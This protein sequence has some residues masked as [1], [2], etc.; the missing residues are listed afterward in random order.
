MNDLIRFT[1]RLEKIVTLWSKCVK[2]FLLLF[3]D[4]HDILD[5]MINH[6]II[7][8]DDLRAEN[9]HRILRNLRRDGPHTRSNLGRQTGLSAASVST[10]ISALT[11][12]GI[13]HSVTDTL[14][15]SA[16]RG[17]PQSSITLSGAAAMVATV[18]LTIDRLYIGLVDY[19]GDALEHSSL[20]IDTRSLTTTELVNLVKR[21]LKNAV[22]LHPNT[23]LRHIG[24]GFQGVTNNTTGDLLWSPILSV[25]QVPMGRELARLFDVSVSVNNDCRLIAKALHHRHADRL[26]DHFTTVLFSHGVG[27]G[28]YLD[29]QA[30][31][32]TQS[33]ALELGHLQHKRNGAQCLC[34]KR[35]CIEAYAANYAIDRAARGGSLEDTPAGLVSTARMQQLTEA[36]QSGNTQA[37]H[38]F[39]Q[40]GMAI[41]KG[42]GTI[43]TLLDPMPVALVGHTTDAYKLMLGELQD[44]IHQGSRAPAGIAGLIHCFN[45]DEPLLKE[46]IMLDALGIIDHQFA[47]LSPAELL[48]T[49]SA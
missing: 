35:G 27:M 25:Q 26:G 12:A 9:R 22:A 4:T 49:G 7:R 5:L 34:G 48:E 29:G 10:L 47:H 6:S 33:S 28:L 14:T 15:G 43:F 39:N 24:F 16:R 44:A 32:G 40:A 21:E 30:F 31:S 46:G 13:V 23:T 45:N 2:L 20:Q 19:A 42:L 36:A 38:A 41:G 8:S 37:Q 11:N 1:S 3:F 17:R 18:S